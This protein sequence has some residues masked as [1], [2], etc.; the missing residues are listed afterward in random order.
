[1]ET[2]MGKMPDTIPQISGLEERLDDGILWERFEISAEPHAITL[3]SEIPTE[4]F[5]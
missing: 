4:P 3:L 2:D 5:L 1:M